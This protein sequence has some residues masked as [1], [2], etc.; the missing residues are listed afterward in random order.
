ME[1]VKQAKV[2]QIGSANGIPKLDG[3]LTWAASLKECQEA[4]CITSMD[5]TGGLDGK[6]YMTAIGDALHYTDI[7][8]PSMYEATQLTGKE[9]CEE[10]EGILPSLWAENAGYQTG[11][12][13]G[14]RYRFCQ[15]EIHSDALRTPRLSIPPAA[16]TA[17]APASSPALSRAGAWRNAPSSATRWV[18]ANCQVIGATWA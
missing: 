18:P 6:V 14:L 13:Q 11:R 15:E 1:Y 3:P 2:V 17:S 10:I 12:R 8:L 7:F 9:T 4:G 16:E 5:V